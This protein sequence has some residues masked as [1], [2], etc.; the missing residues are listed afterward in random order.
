MRLL[1]P[2]ITAVRE[3]YADDKKKQQMEVMAV[4]TKYG[5][6]PVSGCLPLLVQMPILFAL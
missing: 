1:T 6:N 2:E 3:K 4:Y 5:I